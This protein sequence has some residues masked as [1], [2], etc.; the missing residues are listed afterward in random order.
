ML[1]TSAQATAFCSW[2]GKRHLGISRF[3]RLGNWQGSSTLALAWVTH[4]DIDIGHPPWHSVGQPPW[5]WHGSPTLALAWVTHPGTSCFTLA[6]VLL[7][8]P[9]SSVGH[10]PRGPHS[11][12]GYPAPVVQSL[13]NLA[14][15]LTCP[16]SSNCGT[17]KQN[18]PPRAVSHMS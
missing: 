1:F 8:H 12:R 2:P 6:T 10:P 4:F 14:P 7:M 15:S 16:G 18:W 17:A 11:Q 5:H 9:V 13:R 3:A